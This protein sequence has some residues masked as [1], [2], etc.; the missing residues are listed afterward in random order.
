MNRQEI[1]ACIQRHLRDSLAVSGEERT[2]GELVP[3]V[4]AEI[5]V[6]AAT[7]PHR[8]ITIPVWQV[9]AFVDGE[10][11]NDESTAVCL[12][13]LTDNSVLAE[14]IAAVREQRSERPELP[15]SLAARLL[16][17]QPVFEMPRESTGEPTIDLDE[18]LSVAAM[19]ADIPAANASVRRRSPTG[20]SWFLIARD[21]IVVASLLLVIMFAVSRLLPQK[22][23]DVVEG[24]QTPGAQRAD[25]E[26]VPNVRSPGVV[27]EEP[28]S[29][30]QPGDVENSE[31]PQRIPRDQLVHQEN[32]VDPQVVPRAHDP[33]VDPSVSPGDSMA[34]AGPKFHSVRWTNVTGVLATH[35]QVTPSAGLSN[36]V[37]RSVEATVDDDAS[38]AA[39]DREGIALRTMPFSRAEGT[40][41][42]A[43]RV[44]LSGDTLVDVAE[45]SDGALQVVRLQHGGLGLLDMA[46]GTELLLGYA[47][48]RW[49][50]QWKEAASAILR[51]T[52]QGMRI[53]VDGGIVAIN[54]QDFQGQAAVLSFRKSPDISV[55]NG[56]TRMPDWVRSKAGGTKLSQD[57][58]KEL[59]LAENVHA[60]LNQRFDEISK[61]AKISPRQQRN[62]EELAQWR[63][64]LAGAHLYRL[65]GNRHPT[66]RT[67]ALQRLIELPK[68]DPRYREVWDGVARGIDDDRRVAQ[69]RR[70]CEMA[71]NG[72]KPNAA[73]LEQL[74][75]GL[76]SGQLAN[77]A[78]SDY[79]LRRV[80]GGGPLFD[81]AWTGNNQTRGVNLWR[82]YAARARPNA[83]VPTNR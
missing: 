76:Q 3:L 51:H 49:H 31:P 79:L 10:L 28:G 73:Q 18:S 24:N 23:G 36:S 75:A 54:Q 77:R 80:Y 48:Q 35:E 40:W 21:S 9:A 56:A 42:E 52:D 25:V 44:V 61:Q 47:G 58:L 63:A 5:R 68:W 45:S 64:A 13:T 6:T 38:P 66:L 19:D 33:L 70:W 39:K 78:I 29:I 22:A 46:A 62:L 57:I 16:A 83:I 82:N 72:T 1:I 41:G 8:P 69:L 27:D 59:A 11:T 60:K 55:I 26:S 74:F 14:I 65:A 4:A 43:G 67:A 15:P 20:S 53:D 37:W 81:P 12:A 17:M 34:A 2:L 32:I 50:L 30:K 7:I 71:G